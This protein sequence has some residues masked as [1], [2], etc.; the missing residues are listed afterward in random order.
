MNAVSIDAEAVAKSFAEFGYCEKIREEIEREVKDLL[1][2]FKQEVERR[3]IRKGLVYERLVVPDYV[4]IGSIRNTHRGHNL[5]SNE[6]N[7][8]GIPVRISFDRTFSI[9]LVAR[10]VD[11]TKEEYDEDGYPDGEVNGSE[12]II[13]QSN[14]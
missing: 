9:A 12:D 1:R 8:F 14:Y 3:E 10:N 11:Y 2:E 7:I 13:V 4:E 5:F 6:D